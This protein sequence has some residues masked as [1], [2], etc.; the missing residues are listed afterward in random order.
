MLMQVSDFMRALCEENPTVFLCENPHHPGRRLVTSTSGPGGL[1]ES[2]CDT[3]H[4]WQ[5]IC[6]FPDNLSLMMLYQSGY[7]VLIVLK[8]D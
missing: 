8:L 3:S 4:N 2:E 1:L 7:K 5:F 6:K